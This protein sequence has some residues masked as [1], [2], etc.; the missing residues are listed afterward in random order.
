MSVVPSAPG[1]SAPNRAF[2]T[3]FVKKL[4]GLPCLVG[5]A[6]A[7]AGKLTSVPAAISRTT[8]AI[9]GLRPRRRCLASMPKQALTL[10]MQSPRGSEDEECLH[11]GDHL[12]A[13]TVDQLTFSKR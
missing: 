11:E 3:F 9:S 13:L 12:G 4:C 2:A 8:Q 5:F 6:S 1:P 7:E 10:M